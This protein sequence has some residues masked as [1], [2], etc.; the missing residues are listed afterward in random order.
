MPIF[1]QQSS[2]VLIFTQI[3]LRDSQGNLIINLEPTKV[4]YL[5]I[6]ALNSFLNEESTANDP[7]INIDNKKMQVIE[8]SARLDFDSK[9]V[10]SDTTLNTFENGKIITL[11][12]LVHDG[13]PVTPEDDYT[14]IWTFIRLLK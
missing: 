5:N 3:V 4:G 12:R 6:A 14:T 11:V 8:R 7:I 1:A 2:D 10:I 13:I 9:N